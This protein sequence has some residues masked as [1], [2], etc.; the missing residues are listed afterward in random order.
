MS[1]ASKCHNAAC[2]CREVELVISSEWD[3]IAWGIQSLTWH[4]QAMGFMQV[5]T[6]IL[7]CLLA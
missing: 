4:Q 7:R 6:E 3:L 2:S 5:N 1:E